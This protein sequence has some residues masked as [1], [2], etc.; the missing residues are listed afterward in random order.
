MSPENLNALRRAHDAFNAGLNEFLACYTDD[1]ELVPDASWPE[2]GPIR[3]KRAARRWWNEIIAQYEDRFIELEGLLDVD[4]ERA[5]AETKW[6]VR[7]RASE[8]TT[9]FA[10]STLHSMRDGLIC[11]S[12][13]FLDR[14]QALDAAELSE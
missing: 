8:I 14:R 10:V 3:G 11:R 6:H 2:Q 5:I 13:F 9:T 4:G 12:Q 7:G 1:V